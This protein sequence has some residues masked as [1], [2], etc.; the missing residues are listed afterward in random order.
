M[1]GARGPARGP[2]RPRGRR[3]G[4]RGDPARGAG[5]LGRLDL[6][7]AGRSRP[8]RA[9]SDL[10]RPLLELASR[11]DEVG[12]E[13]T[14]APGTLGLSLVDGRGLDE[15]RGRLATLGRHGSAREE[16]LG[17]LHAR[18]HRAA[19]A[20]DRALQA[21]SPEVAAGE[22][23]EALAG[24]DPGGALELGEALLDRI[25]ATFCLGK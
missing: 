12:L 20:L 14:P 16:D 18:V 2:A 23:R 24:L 13:A 11:L 25:F 8:R 3:R 4:R 15:L 5:P 17:R 21:G 7:R 1:L 6:G 10:G 9:A 22:L 19:A